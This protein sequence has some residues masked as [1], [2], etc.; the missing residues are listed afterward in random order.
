MRVPLLLLLS[1]WCL[2]GCFENDDPD[3]SHGDL[4]ALPGEAD[5]PALQLLHGGQQLGME[6]RPSDVCL[7]Q[8]GDQ[9]PHRVREGQLR[10]RAPPLLQDR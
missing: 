5:G 4:R 1:T 8:R 6:A 2:I 9:L 7:D 10:Q 3:L